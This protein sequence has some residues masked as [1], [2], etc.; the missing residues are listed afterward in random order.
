LDKY[1]KTNLPSVSKTPGHTTNSPMISRRV[2][3][4]STTREENKKTISKLKVFSE[5]YSHQFQPVL[6]FCQKLFLKCYPE[7][8]KD[9][10]ENSD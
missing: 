2:T 10:D 8:N 4:K 3:K 7:G 9:L 6:K 5:A 1:H